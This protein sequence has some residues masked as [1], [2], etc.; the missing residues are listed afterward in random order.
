MK[1]AAD[2]T[3]AGMTM[4]ELLVA[5]GLSGLLMAALI[6]AFLPVTRQF[7]QYR[8]L[9]ELRQ[10]L[11]MQLDLMLRDVRQAGY[12]LPVT[13]AQ[14]P[15]WI[16]WVGGTTN[17]IRGVP[18]TGGAPDRLRLA[19]VFD[20]PVAALRSAAARGTTTL[21][22]GTGQG[23]AFDTASRKLIFLG[24]Q[25]LVR[26]TGVSG[27]SLTVSAHASLSGRGLKYAYP[28]GVPLERIEVIEYACDPS[29]TNVFR[30]PYLTRD[31]NQGAAANRLQHVAALGIED[32]RVTESAGV[33]TLELTAVAA[34]ADGRY[35]HPQHGDHFRRETLT[36]RAVARNRILP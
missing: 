11:H 26:V 34:R 22:L 27:D 9:T 1:R 23:A 14:L 2:N 13:N 3:R 36:G 28:A 4:P 21:H 8:E 7:N 19:G 10:T 6:A 16:T 12:G 32:L 33:V 29:R 18:G 20:P 15:A 5:L 30:R 17:V 31:P 35:R 25:E 24:G